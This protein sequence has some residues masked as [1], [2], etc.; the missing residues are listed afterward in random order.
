MEKIR[1]KYLKNYLMVKKSDLSFTVK[2]IHHLISHQIFKLERKKKKILL[3]LMKKTWRGIKIMMENF[4]CLESYDL[5]IIKH[6]SFNF[7]H[8]VH[9]FFSVII[10]TFGFFFDITFVAISITFFFLSLAGI[11]GIFKT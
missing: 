2:N 1:K 10:F 7:F 4:T 3:L 11:T 6:L 8:P 5:W 9:P